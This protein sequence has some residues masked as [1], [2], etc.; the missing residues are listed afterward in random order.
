MS[1][2]AEERCGRNQPQQGIN[3]RWW[4]PEDTIR[5]YRATKRITLDKLQ[6]G[7]M[8][9]PCLLISHM[10]KKEKMEDGATQSLFGCATH[11]TST[12]C[13]GD[14]LNAFWPSNDLQLPADEQISVHNSAT[15]SHNKRRSDRFL[16][17]FSLSFS[18]LTPMIFSLSTS[19]HNSS[20]V[21]WS[22]VASIR[23]QRH[24]FRRKSSAPPSGIRKGDKRVTSGRSV[25]SATVR[26]LT[27]HL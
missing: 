27:L 22:W 15:P 11:S 20:D 23:P 3:I 1:S 14:D 10:C 21:R 26:T 16:L 25:L 9:R 2:Y 8:P 6:E 19:Y 13:R 5:R 24:A 7:E 17:F 18:C 4:R 12:W